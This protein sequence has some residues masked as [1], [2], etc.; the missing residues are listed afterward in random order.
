VIV[1][2]ETGDGQATNGSSIKS[3]DSTNGVMTLATYAPGVRLAGLDHAPGGTCD[4][5]VA[6]G[7]KP[8]PNGATAGTG[9]ILKVSNLMGSPSTSVVA[10][11]QQIWNPIGIRYDAR[12]NS[13]LDIDNLTSPG[14]PP[15][16][17]RGYYGVNVGSGTQT[18]L[19]QERTAISGVSNQ[20]PFGQPWLE[21][22]TYQARDS[23]T[24]G[25]YYVMAAT[26]G[27][28]NG[29]YVGVPNLNVSSEI[30]KVDVNGTATASTFHEFIDTSVAGF[31]HNTTTIAGAGNNYTDFRGICMD[32]NSNLYIT[33]SYFGLIIKMTTDANG[34][35]T[36]S[37]IVASGLDAIETIEWDS[38]TNTLVF[39]QLG[40]VRTLNRINLDG[41]G[42]TTLAS[43]VHVRGIDFCPVP[44]PGVGAGLGL[45]ALVGLRRR[46]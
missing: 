26:G 41:T 8:P 37:S 21:G 4:F 16:V 29:P 45:A 19:Q 23:R 31:I 33:S 18:L 5:F 46:R 40:N 2:T 42:L 6:D 35:F 24:P 1:F 9:R 14:N 11:G 39:A 44:T 10:S 20:T 25:R 34:D 13:V 38:Y 32:G 15:A 36:G 30:W 3:W 43:T 12:S 17:V 27:R 28:Y 7:P 22:G